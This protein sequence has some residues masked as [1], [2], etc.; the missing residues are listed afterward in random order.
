MESDLTNPLAWFHESDGPT[1]QYSLFL[2][3]ETEPFHV[4][5]VTSFLVLEHELRMHGKKYQSADGRAL[6]SGV[7]NA[8]AFS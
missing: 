1:P 8:N 6:W 4:A 7:M 5:I 2:R 3:R